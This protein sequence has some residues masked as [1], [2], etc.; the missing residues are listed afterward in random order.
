MKEN[1]K[2]IALACS[3][4]LLMC[5]GIVGCGSNNKSKTSQETS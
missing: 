4:A 3:L 5:F 1:N 2:R